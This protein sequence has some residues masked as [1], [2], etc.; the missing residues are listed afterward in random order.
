MALGDVTM[1]FPKH[2]A[3]LHLTH[4]QHKA[5]YET[6]LEAIETGTYPETAW[7]SLAQREKALATVEVWE[8]QWYP[9]T[10]VSFHRLLAADLD[11]LLATAADGD[12]A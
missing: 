6:V 1:Q 12:A 10:P 7:V 4:N 2:D 9:R 3:S 11:V 8:L 5:Y